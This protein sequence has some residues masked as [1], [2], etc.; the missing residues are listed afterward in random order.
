MGCAHNESTTRSSGLEGVACAIANILQ[1]A[2]NDAFLLYS[3]SQADLIA[4]PFL[5]SEYPFHHWFGLLH[6]HVDYLR[7]F[8]D[9]RPGSTTTIKPLNCAGALLRHG[10]CAKARPSF[11]RSPGLTILYY[12]EVTT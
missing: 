8:S 9:N 5:V 10:L 7:Q 11:D 2:E 4:Y 6:K 3:V 12:S 1:S